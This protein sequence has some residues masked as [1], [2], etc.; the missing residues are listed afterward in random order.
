MAAVG[1]SYREQ[2][3]RYRRYFRRIIQ[4]YEQRP[5]VKTSVELLLT[6]GTIS[7]FAVFAIRPTLN[8]IAELLA[9]TRTQEE[10]QQKLQEKIGALGV[11][12]TTWVEEQERITLLNQALPDNSNPESYLQQIEGLTAK[13]GL[14]LITFN[15]DRVLLFGKEEA[16][17]QREKPEN[18]IPGIENMDVSLSI[19]GQYESLLSFLADLG[20]LRRPILVDS[21]SFGASRGNA[22]GP[23]IL[24]VSGKVPYY[25]VKENEK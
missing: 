22:P 2:Y 7:F 6:L 14:Q 11:A 16:K 25:Q 20:N 18:A 8:T 17:S 9:T 10:I 24:T 19:S 5:E 12:Q 4:V 1:T 21:L 13:H 15:I 23:L 3:A